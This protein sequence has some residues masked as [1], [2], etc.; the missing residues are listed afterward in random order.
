MN[1]WIH[2][3]LH[4][5]THTRTH[6]QTHTHTRTHKHTHTHTNTHTHAHTNTH[7]HAHTNGYSKIYNRATCACQQ[8]ID[9]PRSNDGTRSSCNEWYTYYVTQKLG[10]YGIPGFLLGTH[11]HKYSVEDFRAAYINT[12]TYMYTHAYIHRHTHIHVHTCIHT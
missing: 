1:G 12:H 2:L 4:A 10:Y 7:T 3:H 9:I 11:I 6:T 8:I 5:Y